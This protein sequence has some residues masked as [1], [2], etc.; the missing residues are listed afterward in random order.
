MHSAPFS[1][2]IPLT[3]PSPR[4]PVVTSKPWSTLFSLPGG[5]SPLGPPGNSCLASPQV[6]PSLAQAEHTG[7]SCGLHLPPSALSPCQVGA[8]SHREAS[9]P[10][11]HT[12]FPVPSS[13]W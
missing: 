3:C 10:K 9:P 7:F 2:S 13:K 11:L 5:P 1:P 8:T 6:S 12:T 4:L